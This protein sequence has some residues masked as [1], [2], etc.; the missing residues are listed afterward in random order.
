M[1]DVGVAKLLRLVVF[2]QVVFALRQSE[3]ALERGAN[4]L[5]TVLSVLRRIETKERSDPSA[6][7]VFGYRLEV[8]DVLDCS[9][10]RQLGSDG[11]CSRRIDGGRVHAA[12]VEIADLL[13]I[14]TWCGLGA[15]GSLQNLAQVLLVLVRKLTE[16]AP[17]RIFRRN[18]VGFHPPAHRELVEI[19]AR[20]AGLVEIRSLEAPRTW[21]VRH[22][23]RRAEPGAGETSARIPADATM[24]P[25][26]KNRFDIGSPV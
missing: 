25:A 9:D 19:V 18:R 24:L 13:L 23:H 10:A 14:R 5:R 2:F 3:A 17:A 12:R 1:L 26:R 4:H 22:F 11:F 21:L 7:K 15:G 20:F 6:L 16:R 8:C